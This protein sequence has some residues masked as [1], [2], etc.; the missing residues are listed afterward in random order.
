MFSVRYLSAR[1][2]FTTPGLQVRGIGINETMPPCL[3]RRPQGTGD[4]LFMLFHDPVHIG[5]GAKTPEPAGTLMIWPREAGHYYGNP[6]RRWRHSWVHCA[7]EQIESVLAVPP[8]RVDRPVR[9]INPARVSRALVDLH[10]E[11]RGGTRVDPVIVRN[12][13]VNLVRESAR[14]RDIRSR[15]VSASPGVGL[16]RARDLIESHYDETFHLADLAR[17]A[18][19]SVSHF[20]TEFRR[21]YGVPPIAFLL[22]R[23]L[24]AAMTLLLGTDLPIGVIGAR[25][26]CTDPYQF[27]K[28]FKQHFGRSPRAEREHGHHKSRVKPSARDRD[29]SSLRRR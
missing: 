14:T 29:H 17:Q 9:P 6:A 3:V 11:L 5:A 4:C 22:Q 15:P 8:V 21:H 28:L 10:E 16:V 1:P 23:R 24:S 27:S 12:L 26:G 13:L 20:C 18:G 7:G 2:V 25:V 19:L